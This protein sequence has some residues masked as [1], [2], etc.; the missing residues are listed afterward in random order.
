MWIGRLGNDKA[1]VQARWEVSR[2]HMYARKWFV[3]DEDLYS[4]A[5]WHATGSFKQ[6]PHRTGSLF[7]LSWGEIAI[8]LAVLAIELYGI[9]RAITRNELLNSSSSGS[10]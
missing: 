10:Q 8:A 1:T 6:Q 4:D 3:A 7:L 2:L 9:R 5:L